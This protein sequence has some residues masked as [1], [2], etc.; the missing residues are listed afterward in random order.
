MLPPHSAMSPTLAALV[1]GTAAHGPSV[2][3][4]I[5]QG[6][7]S[8]VLRSAAAARAAAA[9]LM[10]LLDGARS[11]AD[12]AK[13]IADGVKAAYE[14]DSF[15][16]EGFVRARHILFLASEGDC[17]AKAAALTARIERGEIDFDD[18][19]LRFSACPTR[20]LHGALGT[21]ASLSR[22]REGTLSGD[23]MP[24]DGKDTAAFDRLVQTAEVGRLCTVASQWGT[25]IVLV[26]ARGGE[27][28]GEGGGGE[29]EAQKVEAS[30]STGTGFGGSAAVTSRA[31]KAKG[32]RGGSRRR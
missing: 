26:E 10:G 6:P 3:V 28:G 5:A 29:G 11:V 17:E 15:V 7:P 23:S 12:G 24:Y 13:S 30:A 21:F 16:P 25:H 22:L 1:I 18:A 8:H 4:C 27:G 2:H 19:A 32:R 20:D 31:G 14:D 9:P